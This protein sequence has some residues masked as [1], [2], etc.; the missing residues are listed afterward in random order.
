MN[1][2]LYT[3]AGDEAIVELLKASVA[4]FSPSV[5]RKAI[6]LVEARGVMGT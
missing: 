4:V 5:D 1:D 2:R 3:V 6:L